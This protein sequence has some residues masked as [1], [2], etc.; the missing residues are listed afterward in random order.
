MGRFADIVLQPA[1]DARD[2]KVVMMP[3]HLERVDENLMLRKKVY[4]L[5][6]SNSGT[7]KTAFVDH[8]YILAPYEAWRKAKEAG[9]VD[10]SFKSIYVAAER[11]EAEKLAKWACW[12]LYQDYRYQISVETFMGFSKMRA[13]KEAW[14]RFKMAQDWVDEL[15]DHVDL[16]SHSMS[17]TEY[18][19]LIDY[20]A[21][22][23][24]I[25]VEADTIGIKDDNGGYQAFFTPQQSRTKNTGE[26]VEYLNYVDATGKVHEIVPQTKMYFPHRPKEIVQLV[27][28]HIGKT[29]GPGSDKE[30]TDKISQIAADA[31]DTYHHSPVIVSQ[32]NR[33]VGNIDRIKIYKDDLS[34]NLDDFKN[35][36]NAVEDCD[37]ALALFNPLRYSAYDNKGFYKE[38]NI[39]NRMVTAIGQNRFRLLSILKNSY[40][41][42]NLNYG[43][44]FLG[45]VM[46]FT[47]LPKPDQVDELERVYREIAMGL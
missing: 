14:E 41:D 24:G 19:T 17:P 46:N 39:R 29:R 11:P 9:V 12:K 6:G 23:D 5:I 34:P 2:G 43:L 3:I 28:D 21:K 18:S 22:K 4:T 7:G 13:T 42:D 35:T 8:A 1:Q 37:V 33:A 45:E 32:F 27:Y 47:T 44:K 20:H 40:G 25:L 31:R 16:K 36:G 26:V 30:R 10:T 15:L 38:Y